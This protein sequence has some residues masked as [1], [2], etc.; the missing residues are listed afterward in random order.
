MPTSVTIT[1]SGTPML[2]A[3]RA[4]PGAMIRH[5]ATTIQVDAGRATALRLTEAG[6]GLNDLDA[7]LITH[8][9]SDHLLGVP[10]LALTRWTSNGPVPYAGLPIHCPLGPAVDYLEAMFDQLAPDIQSRRGV[11]NYPDDPHPTVHP[12]E[13]PAPDSGVAPV[14]TYGEVV[15]EAATVDHGD[16]APAVGYRFTTPDGVIVVSG[17]TRVCAAVE[18]LARGAD[19][20]VHEAFVG[21][22]LVRRGL[23]AARLANLG[24]HHADAA[25]VG[26]MAARLEVPALVITHLVPSPGSPEEAARF[27]DEVRAGGYDGDLTIAED[28]HTAMIPVPAGQ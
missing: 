7:L 23:S 4:G 13:P 10:D 19:I 11:S 21:E 28:L 8:H 20:L 27:R 2:A 3:G 18:Q 5:D 1:G 12:F 24:H 14:A 25:E 16:L 26:A 15:I 6:V 22:L 9:H 17:D